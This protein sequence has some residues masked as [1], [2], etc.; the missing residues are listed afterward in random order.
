MKYIS[1]NGT[2]IIGTA[3]KVLATARISDIDA[4]TGLPVY[5]GGTE[6]HWDTQETLG[7]NGHILFVCEDGDEWTFAELRPLTPESE[8]IAGP[9]L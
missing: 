5:E 7:R 1:P 6:V 2:A 3:E 8:P 4:E 9:T